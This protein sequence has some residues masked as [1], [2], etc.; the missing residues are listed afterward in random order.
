MGVEVTVGSVVTVVRSVAPLL[1]AAV[2]MFEARVLSPAEVS[3]EV[4]RSV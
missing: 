4:V 1:P 3:K 2:L